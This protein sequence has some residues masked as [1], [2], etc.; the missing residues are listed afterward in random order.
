MGD[1]TAIADRVLA[2]KDLP[3]E[4]ALS[5]LRAPD[6][7]L[8][9]VLAAAYK[10][11]RHFHGN[12]VKIHV[13]ENAMSGMCPED[14]KFCSQSNIATGEIERYRLESKDEMVAAARKAKAAGAYKYCIVTSTRGPSDPQLSTICAAVREIKDT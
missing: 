14:C 1:W 13:L 10:V 9:E 3:R 5:V 11:R 12:R 4:E 6:A 2:G 8:L 7:D